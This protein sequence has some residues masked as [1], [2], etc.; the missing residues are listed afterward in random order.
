[1]AMRQ[2]QFSGPL[3]H[4]DQ[5]NK[6][7]PETRKAIV[8][9]NRIRKDFIADDIGIGFKAIASDEKQYGPIIAN[10]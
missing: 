1:M 5:L 10:V 8:E 9:A 3:P 4:P 2:E 6:F 7:D